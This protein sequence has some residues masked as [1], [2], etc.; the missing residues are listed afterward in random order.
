MASPR[1]TF[2]QE[3]RELDDQILIMGKEAESMLE[4]ALIAL[5]EQNLD[6]AHETI[7]HDDIVDDMRFSIEKKCIELIATQHPKAKDLRRIFAAIAIASDVERVADYSVDIAKIV[8][9]LPDKPF[10]K[11][12]IDIPKMERAVAKML[13]EGLEGF[14]SRDLDLIKK[15]LLSDDEIDALYEMLHDELVDFMKRDPST[16]DQAVQLLFVSRYLERIADHITNIGER[17]FYVETGQVI[18]M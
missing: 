2:S 6:L 15:V 11:P 17:V 18:K 10:F 5:A 14:V 12:L 3:L 9:R 13:R 16:I 1:T 4:N 7:N 8:R